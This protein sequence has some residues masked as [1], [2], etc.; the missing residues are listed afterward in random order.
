[1]H[2]AKRKVQT[3]GAPIFKKAMEHEDIGGVKYN[4]GWVAILESDLV[5]PNK[6]DHFAVPPS[7]D[8]L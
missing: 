4:S 7:H 1:M 6:T 3:I 8:T 5:R 2:G